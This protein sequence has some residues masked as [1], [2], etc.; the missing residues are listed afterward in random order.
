MVKPWF[1]TMIRLEEG[2]S[3]EVEE[4]GIIFVTSVSIKFFKMKWQF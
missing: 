1:Y 2:L 4:I 3:E